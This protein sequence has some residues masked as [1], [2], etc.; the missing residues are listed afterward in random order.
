MRNVSQKILN[1]ISDKSNKSG[2]L[3]FVYFPLSQMY[4]LILK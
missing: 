4:K 3:M 1:G 2:L